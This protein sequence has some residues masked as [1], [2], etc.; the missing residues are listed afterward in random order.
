MKIERE[1]VSL[2]RAIIYRSGKENRDFQDKLDFYNLFHF[3][4]T[5][6]FL[7]IIE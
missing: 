1:I 2:L 5:Y 7:D 4:L 3:L 6:W